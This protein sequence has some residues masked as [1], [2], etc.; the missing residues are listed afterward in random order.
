MACFERTISNFEKRLG[1][2]IETLRKR[3]ESKDKDV[4]TKAAHLLN[5]ICNKEFLLTNLGLLDICSLLG[6]ISSNLQTVHQFP[7]G[8]PK[9]QDRLIKIMRRMERLSLTEGCK[10]SQILKL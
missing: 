8:I 5:S 3:T 7:W 9:Q 10:R 6:S 2:T 4:K 1:I